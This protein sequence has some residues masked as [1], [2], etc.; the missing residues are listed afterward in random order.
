MSKV[1]VLVAGILVSNSRSEQQGAENKNQQP[2]ITQRWNFLR[3]ALKSVQPKGTSRNHEF[4]FFHFIFLIFFSSTAAQETE[5]QEISAQTEVNC[6]LQK[7]RKF[8]RR[9]GKHFNPLAGGL[10]YFFLI[11][12]RFFCPVKDGVQRIRNFFLPNF[13][14]NCARFRVRMRKLCLFQG[15]TSVSGFFERQTQIG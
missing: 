6:G 10:N 11:F 2:K 3:S 12:L 4:F 5:A 1:L 13:K 7:I 15:R 8:L 14:K 9:L